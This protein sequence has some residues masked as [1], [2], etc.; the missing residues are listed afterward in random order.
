MEV[1]K[2]PQ[3]VRSL[4]VIVSSFSENYPKLFL[5]EILV[6]AANHRPEFQQYFSTTYHKGTKEGLD[7]G[8]RGVVSIEPTYTPAIH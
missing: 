7:S 3:N 4:N 8:K 1:H 2:Y 6:S 5:H